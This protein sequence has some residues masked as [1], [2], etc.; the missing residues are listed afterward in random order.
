MP[1]LMPSVM[2]SS[3][4]FQLSAVSVAFGSMSWLTLPSLLTAVFVFHALVD[5]NG[6]SEKATHKHDT[7][8]PSC[9]SGVPCVFLCCLFVPQWPPTSALRLLDMHTTARI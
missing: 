7:L 1:S 9:S 5:Y 4:L 3:F 2:P 8:A 6:L